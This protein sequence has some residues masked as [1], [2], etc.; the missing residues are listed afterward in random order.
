MPTPTWSRAGLAVVVLATALGACSAAAPAVRDRE[1]VS[2]AVRQGGAPKALVANTR[3]ALRFSEADLGANA[4]CNGLGGTYRIEL[5]RLLYERG[6]QTLMGC[7]P[8][9]EAQDAW[10]V[11]F[12]DSDP[13]IVLA[14]NDLTLDNGAISIHLVDREVAEPDLNIVGPT[15]TVESIV[16][17]DTASSVPAG[18][19]ATL[20]FKD[21]GTFEVDAGC[22]RGGGTWS[23]EGAGIRVKDIGLTK[24]AC[25]GPRA[26][27]EGA[28]MQV[29]G[30]EL[31]QARIDA[32]VMTLSGGNAGLQL[33]G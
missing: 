12:L 26:A 27:L 31:L 11:D 20:V 30:A 6:G 28:V 29:L 10:L 21:D 14:G 22:N 8:P 23:L 5:G 25:D 33:R 17:G 16:D 13:T 24:M 18:A 1:F 3:I 32:R 9:L 15:W 4:G 2:V 19:T 7:E